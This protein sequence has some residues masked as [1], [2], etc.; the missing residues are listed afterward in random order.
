LTGT[1]FTGDGGSDGDTV[2]ISGISGGGGFS[3]VASLRIV[4]K[5][6]ADNEPIEGVVFDLLIKDPVTGLGIEPGR[7][8]TTNA[9]GV[10]SFARIISNSGRVYVL[11]EVSAPTGYTITEA[12]V[13]GAMLLTAFEI[14][15]DDFLTAFGTG[16]L[17]LNVT[18][19]NQRATYPIW[20]SKTSNWSGASLS[21]AVFTLKQAG[22]V[23]DTATSSD[24]GAVAFTDIPWGEYTLEETTELPGH[25]PD[26]TVY[27]VNIEPNGSYTIKKGGAVVVAVD[28]STGVPTRTT[29]DPIVN[30]FIE[31]GISFQK[32]SDIDDDVDGAVFTLK[33][34]GLEIATATSGI[35]GTVE[36]TSLATGNYTLQEKTALAGHKLDTTIYAVKIFADGSYIIMNG[37]TVV[38]EKDK[39]GNVVD[40]KNAAIVN[41]YLF[42]FSLQKTSNRNGADVSGAQFTLKNQA[43]GQVDATAT[44][45]SDGTVAFTGVVLGH[46]M[47]EETKAPANHIKSDT[48]YFIEI[49]EDGSFT[50]KIDGGTI[51]DSTVNA[52]LFTVENTF[53]SGGGSPGGG[54]RGSS[55]GGNPLPLITAPPVAPSS[56]GGYTGNPNENGFIPIG[57]LPTPLADLALFQLLDDLIPLAGLPFTGITDWNFIIV[58]LA[59]AGALFVCTGLIIRK[60]RMRK[61]KEH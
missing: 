31:Y 49:K 16:S 58:L 37:N 4:K 11:R 14:D 10:A 6:G 60:R 57:D 44:S 9:L 30:E 55:G 27:I 24:S 59:G 29:D 33:Q 51:F 19:A 22:A 26:A 39:D 1:V 32:A 56:P 2:T 35:D 13:D 17:P 36:F 47:L 54:G 53:H 12:K 61:G 50:I 45:G 21:G 25:E 48:K 46:Y 7:R 5:D 42:D 43:T 40:G 28:R 8:A 15:H 18:V 20:F 34:A 3:G 41:Q 38:V 23:V 52:S